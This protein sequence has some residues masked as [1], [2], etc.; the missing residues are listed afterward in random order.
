[1]KLKSN[2]KYSSII[3]LLLFQKV[4]TNNLW[5]NHGWEMFDYISDARS[6]SLAKATTA[7]EYNQPG[8]SLNNP[9]FLSSSKYN[10][11]LT[12]QSRFAGL[13]NSML[14]KKSWYR[15]KSLFD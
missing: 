15:V 12:H 7:F 3:L 2:L 10:L 11:S 8:A 14:G 13:I 5:V 6:S 4:F 1:M 9:I